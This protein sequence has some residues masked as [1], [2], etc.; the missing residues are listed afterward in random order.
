MKKLSMVV[1]ATM[2]IAGMAYAS[3]LSVPWFVDFPATALGLPPSGN[4]VTTTVF[5]KSNVDE[6]V[7]CEI[8][9]FA[10]DGTPLG[11]GIVGTPSEN[12]PITFEVAPQS[13]LAF[14][15]VAIDPSPAA[16]TNIA[17][18]N[19]LGE[20]ITVDG[21]AGGAEAAQGVLVPIRPR[22][23]GQNHS[24]GSITVSWVGQPTDVQGMSLTL[25]GPDRGLW[26]YSYLLPP[27]A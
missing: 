19:H 8:Q 16:G 23:A 2:L 20:P 27:G 6:V 24:N 1:V 22:P 10:A 11:P 12:V 5:L 14:R 3:S 18:W 26:S 9:Y 25:S 7:T 17:V 21:Q 4:A 13:A 15:P